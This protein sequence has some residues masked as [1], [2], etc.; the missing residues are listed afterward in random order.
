MVFVV[1]R[2]QNCILCI[3]LKAGY[4]GLGIRDGEYKRG[5][6]QFTGI[7]AN[8]VLLFCRAMVAF[9]EWTVMRVRSGKRCFGCK[10]VRACVLQNE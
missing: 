1:V 3:H 8:R 10:T 7:I 2:I 6:K 5:I 9:L 4:Y